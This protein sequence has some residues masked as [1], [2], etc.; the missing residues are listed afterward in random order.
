VV[1]TPI[2]EE[3]SRRGPS[4]GFLSDAYPFLGQRHSPPDHVQ[5]GPKLVLGDGGGAET[6]TH[7]LASLEVLMQPLFSA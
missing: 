6:T 2:V 7:G 4:G 3:E 1:V 5:V